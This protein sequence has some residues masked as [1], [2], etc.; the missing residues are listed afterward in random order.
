VQITPVK[1]IRKENERMETIRISDS[2]YLFNSY[3]EFIDLSFNQYLLM[4]ES[5]ILI[6]T[7]SID[8]TAAILPNIKELLGSRQL[9]YVF[10][11]H[12]E[13]D[14]CGG[15]GLL[16]SHYP[17]VKPICS[18]VTARQL[19]GFGITKDIIVKNPGDSL[20]IGN[21]KLKFISYPSEMH[22][23][24]G[25]MAFESEQGM[26]FSGDVFIRRGKLENA[27]I[28]S[29]LDEEVQKISLEQV[30]SPTAHKLLQ[31]TILSLPVKYIMPGHGPCLKV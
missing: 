14:E 26:L 16:I 19:M 29:R 25:L 1:R 27:V 12:F 15:L 7:G 8:Q 6:H 4:G 21:H 2:T 23:W 11:S 28:T 10:V 9:E 13:S 5:P 22:L 18:P 17:Q 31:E 20:D 3:I 30:P 24:E